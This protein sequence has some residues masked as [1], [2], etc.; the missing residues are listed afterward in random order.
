MGIQL[1][2]TGGGLTMLLLNG[3]TPLIL[4]NST[5]FTA[6]QKSH[7]TLEHLLDEKQSFNILLTI[8]M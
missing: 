8:S 7:L 3:F 4:P 2:Y 6:L 5:G 1:K